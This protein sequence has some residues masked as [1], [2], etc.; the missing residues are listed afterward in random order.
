LRAA[1]GRE[2]GD[3]QNP[4]PAFSQKGEGGCFFCGEV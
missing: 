4:R 3:V 1:K 2:E